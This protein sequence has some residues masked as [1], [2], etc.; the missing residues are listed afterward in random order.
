MSSKQLHLLFKADNLTN[1]ICYC[2]EIWEPHF[3]EP[4]GPVQACTGIALSFN[5]GK[6][7]KKMGT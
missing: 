3:L 2:Y 7:C 1:F 5:W 6:A 4:S